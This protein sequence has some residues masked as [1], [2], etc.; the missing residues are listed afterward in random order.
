M[1]PVKHGIRSKGHTGLLGKIEMADQT[2]RRLEEL[3]QDTRDWL[4]DLR[5]DEL[6]TLQAVVELP[7]DDVRQAF[8]MVHDLQTVGRFTKWLVITFIG[9]FLGTVVLYENIIKVIGYIRGG[10]AQ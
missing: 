5:P 10:P 6:K 3:P 9:I 7:A 8:K 4:A 2:P 1:I